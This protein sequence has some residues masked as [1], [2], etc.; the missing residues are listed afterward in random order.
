MSQPMEHRLIVVTNNE[1][2]YQRI[3]GIQLD[4]WLA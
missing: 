1:S 2:H 4:N 3:A